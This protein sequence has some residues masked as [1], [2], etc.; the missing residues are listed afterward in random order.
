MNILLLLL[1]AIQGIFNLLKGAIQILPNAIHHA[2]MVIFREVLHTGW[3]VTAAMPIPSALAGF[4]EFP[5]PGP[6]GWALIALGVPTAFAILS[7]G[8]ALKMARRLI[9]FVGR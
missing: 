4:T 9:P 8:F 7:A 1:Q 5:D 2:A 3:N 6:L